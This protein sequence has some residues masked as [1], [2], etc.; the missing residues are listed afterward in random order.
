MILWAFEQ[1]GIGS[2]PTA[3]GEYKQFHKSFPSEGCMIIINVTEHSEHKALANIEFIDQ[4]GQLIASIAN[5]ECVIDASLEETF[6]KN[7]L[8]IPSIN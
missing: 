7:K 8:Q 2:L 1:F 4:N 6:A 3:I 5:Y